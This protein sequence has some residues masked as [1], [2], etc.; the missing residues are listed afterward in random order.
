MNCWKGTDSI[1]TIFM[2]LI[3]S[4]FICRPS[5]FASM[6]ISVDLYV[7]PDTTEYQHLDTGLS[8]SVGISES[9]LLTSS[10]QMK[11]SVQISQIY[12]YTRQGFL[13]PDSMNLLAFR[14][15]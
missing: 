14:S 1:K 3:N 2:A 15:F 7:T 13:L 6:L 10:Y 4:L 9:A 8:F 12:M 11:L 5:E